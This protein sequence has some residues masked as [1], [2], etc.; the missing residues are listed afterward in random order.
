MINRLASAIYNDI[1]G[2]LRGYHVNHSI[3]LEQLEDDIIS[4]RLAVI[5][6]YSLKGILP[7]K[8]LLESINCI[9]VD[10]K[11]LNR[12]ACN[13]TYIGK[14]QLH[15]TIPQIMSDI[16]GSDCIDFIGSTDRELSFTVYTSMRNLK[17]YTKYRRRA[18]DKPY[19]YLD[20]VPNNDGWIDGY[21]FNAPYLKE[22]S[23]VAIFKDPRELENYKCCPTDSQ[24][25]SFIDYEVRK[26]VTSQYIYYYR[27]MAPS[28]IPNKQEYTAS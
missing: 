2:G 22:I 4:T 27:Q 26:R 5:K 11:D 6:E 16:F 13:S 12:C 25:F 14:P 8:D 17:T 18:K 1:V 3:S 10:C 20:T 28:I 21:I 24:K 19:V 23:V 15:F 9:S 7:I